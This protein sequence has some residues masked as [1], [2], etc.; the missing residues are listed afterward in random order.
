[1]T[2]LLLLLTAVPVLIYYFVSNHYALAARLFL[3]QFVCGDRAVERIVTVWSAR[4]QLQCMAE[5]FTYALGLLLVIWATEYRVRVAIRWARSR[6]RGDS[7]V[8]A[9]V[10]SHEKEDVS[11]SKHES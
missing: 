4:N 7:E 1:M 6:R 10:G 3:Y 5:V 11:R 2:T 9:D 8:V